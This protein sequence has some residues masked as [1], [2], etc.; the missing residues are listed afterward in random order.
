MEQSVFFSSGKGAQNRHTRL[1]GDPE[2]L[3]KTTGVGQPPGDDQ[4]VLAIPPGT[5]VHHHDHVA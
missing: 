3:M 2:S 4:P 5:N 1:R